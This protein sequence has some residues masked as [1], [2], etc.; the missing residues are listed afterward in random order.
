MEIP[1]VNAVSFWDETGKKMDVNTEELNG[2]LEYQKIWKKNDAAL[3]DTVCTTRVK[4]IR[5]STDREVL[6]DLLRRDHETKT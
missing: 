1:N 6:D 2:R 4:L 5:L 3:V